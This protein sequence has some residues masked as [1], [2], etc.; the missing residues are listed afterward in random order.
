MMP[1]KRSRQAVSDSAD[2]LSMPQGRDRRLGTYFS[3]QNQYPE[4]YGVGMNGLIGNPSDRR[5]VQAL[6]LKGYLLFFDQILANYMAH[7]AQ[8]KELLARSTPVW[9]TYFSQKIKRSALRDI[10]KLLGDKADDFGA[11]EQFEKVLEQLEGEQADGLPSPRFTDRRNRLLDHLLGRF[12]EQFNDY[13]LLMH[14]LF[15]KKRAGQEVLR[16][17]LLL[18][19]E[20]DQLSA[21]RALGMD[22]VNAFYKGL[23][24]KPIEDKGGQPIP[25]QVWYA[26]KDAQPEGENWNA[27]GA[28]HRI[29]RLCGIGNY[30]NHF[31]S[32]ADYSPF[33]KRK[34][35]GNP[36]SPLAL[37]DR[38]DQVLF[39]LRQKHATEAKDMEVMQEAIQQALSVSN[40]RM[41]ENAAGKFLFQILHKEGTALTK[42]S[43]RFDSQQE[44]LEAI[45]EMIEFLN[46]TF[47]DE[48]IYL[49]EHLLL[50][51]RKDNDVF[52]PICTDT[53]CKSCATLDPYSFKVSV[54][55]PG[56]TERFAS[57]DF[58]RYMETIIRQELPAHVLAR[59][60]WIGEDQMAIFEARYKAWLEYQQG[61]LDGASA[62]NANTTLNE[63]IDILNQLYTI[64]PKGTLHDCEDGADTNPIILGRTQIG[65]LPETDDDA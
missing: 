35:E 62:D 1:K 18:L 46:D 4:T 11:Y 48:G 65:T 55:L 51:S 34:P 49:V 57:P 64:Y 28:Q 31:V 21:R 56:Y 54:V 37:V 59:I 22:Y 19:R 12:A 6:Q 30:R 42:N 36:D 10:H 9:R 41:K 60:C 38:N 45:E 14:S 32:G 7:L 17:K 40:Y 44:R 58:R 27:A 52:L 20:Y 2:D 25:K 63:L 23:D 47:S 13:V 53:D 61:R 3:F 29:A 26:L 33:F 15:G 8:F 24:G 39:V 50:R 5:R 16:D 43:A